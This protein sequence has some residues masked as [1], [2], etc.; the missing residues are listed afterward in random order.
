MVASRYWLVDVEGDGLPYLVWLNSNGLAGVKVDGHGGFRSGLK[1]L[2]ESFSKSKLQGNT[3][4]QE[5]IRFGKVR[6]GSGL[7]D[8]IAMSSLGVVIADNNGTSFGAVHLV[9]HLAYPAAGAA[10]WNPQQAAA[11][12]ALVD[13]FGTGALDIVIPGSAGLLYSTPVKN[14][15]STFKPLTAHDGFNYWSS[16]QFYT[17]MS[18]TRI[19]GRTAIAGWTP[20]GLAFSNFTTI[21]R[22]AAVDQFRV[23]CNDCFVS[24]PD[25]LHQWQES[26]MTAA[27]F[28]T[29]F[30]DLKNTGSPQAFAVWGKGLFASDIA[31]LAGYR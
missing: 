27:P 25:W 5:S 3:V 6:A 1:A 18:A 4:Y 8:V 11:N 26:N 28:Q 9:P 15:F 29:G 23:L 31:S 19:G 24:L 17:S 21:E 7:P 30:A 22:R 13:L 20:V 14:S 16:P 2:A 12:L 10:L